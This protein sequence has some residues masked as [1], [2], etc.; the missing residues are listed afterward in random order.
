MKDIN[1]PNDNISQSLDELTKDVNEIIIKLETEKNLENSIDYYQKLIRLNNI[2]E[3]KFQKRSKQINQT[4]KE[5]IDKIIS[6]QN[7]K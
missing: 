5:K 4:T 1:L 6:K 3:K 7:A 2:I